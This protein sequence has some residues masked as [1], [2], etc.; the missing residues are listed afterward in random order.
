MYLV[1]QIELLPVTALSLK[2]ET[3]K[4]PELS[5]IVTFAQSGWP[6]TVSENLQPFF[7]RRD[8]LTIKQGCL[9][10]GARMVIPHKYRQKVLDELHGGHMGMVKMKALARAHV[11]WPNIDQDIEGASQSCTGC[12]LMK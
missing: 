6:R 4:D 8:E 7:V 3:T 10:W 11:W 12:Q 2:A 5:K 1:Q 9:M